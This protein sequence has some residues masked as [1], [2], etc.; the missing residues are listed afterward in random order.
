[1]AAI[2]TV[3][4]EARQPRKIILLERIDKLQDIRGRFRLKTIAF[5][6]FVNEDRARAAFEEASNEGTKEHKKPASGRKRA[7]T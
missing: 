5:Q 3:I 6:Y 2:S 4:R 1:M 7:E